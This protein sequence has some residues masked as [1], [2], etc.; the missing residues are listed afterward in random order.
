MPSINHRPKQ[1]FFIFFTSPRRDQRPE[2]GFFAKNLPPLPILNFRPPRSCTSTARAVQRLLK[3]Y[4]IRPPSSSPPPSFAVH[5][6]PRSVPER[7][8]PLG[9]SC[10]FRRVLFYI[11]KGKKNNVFKIRI[12]REHV[13]V[14]SRRCNNMYTKYKMTNINGISIDIETNRNMARIM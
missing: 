3:Q 14:H 9:R 1:C 12:R 13:H 4:Y 8:E 5:F 7:R 2:H 11:V 6:V 10:V